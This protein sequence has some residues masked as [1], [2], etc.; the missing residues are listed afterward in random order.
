LEVAG[1][2]ATAQEGARATQ[3]AAPVATIAAGATATR[4][5][6]ISRLE[7]T[8]TAQ[9]LRSLVDQAVA[10]TAAAQPT[11]TPVPPT[12]TPQPATATST[13]APIT[14]PQAPIVV[15]SPEYVPVP[16]PVP[17]P[18]YGTPQFVIDAINSSN[19]AYSLAKWTLN[20]RDLEVG[21]S[22]QELADSR[23]YVQGLMKNRTRVVST[24]VRGDVTTWRYVTSTRLLAS[25]DEVWRFANYD[26]DTYTLKKNISPRLYRN[27]YTVDLLNGRWKVTLDDV[28][29]RNGEAI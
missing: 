9:A 15:L 11:A 6:E 12:S 22:G 16:V 5:A 21:I 18:T 19:N 1:V 29:N 2:Q 8:A 10:A 20:Q 25:T 3:T 17:V 23:A 7:A 24:L 26:A 4:D 28:P 27:D 13:P 14:P